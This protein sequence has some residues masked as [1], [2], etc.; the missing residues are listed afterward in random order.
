MV[1]MFEKR[2]KTNWVD[3]NNVVL[4][5]DT[6]QSCC[7]D[8]GYLYY[9]TQKYNEH[10]ICDLENGNNDYVF[11]KEFCVIGE[12]AFDY[13]EHDHYKKLS[14]LENGDIV[15]F[16]LISETKGD[17]YIT[18]YNAHNGYYAHGFSMKLANSVK[19]IHEGYL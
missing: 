6:Y 12:E 10:D 7:E 4:G 19:N 15:T 14:D 5:Y 9:F 2:G 3:S 8:A 18:L 16:K 17:I 1:K 11:D 13:F